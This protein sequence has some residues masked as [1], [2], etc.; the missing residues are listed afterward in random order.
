[1]GTRVLFANAFDEQY[2]KDQVLRQMHL[3]RPAADV[4]VH[5]TRPAHEPA[6]EGNVL[7]TIR[8]RGRL[9]VG[10]LPNA[11]PFA[12]FN[13][14]HEL[15]GYDIELAH[16]LAGEL[17]VHLEFVPV[18]REHLSEDLAHGYCDIVMS[19]VPVTTDL[20]SRALMTRRVS[21]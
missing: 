2:T 3:L 1:M 17:R 12:F 4:V 19:G 7:E 21:R 18:V 11:L 6:P 16:Q 15:V 14:R 10:Y 9:R 5:H 20:A 13:Q 8:A